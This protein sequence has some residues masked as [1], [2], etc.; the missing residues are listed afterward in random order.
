[1]V[2][3]NEAEM[4]TDNSNIIS[5]LTFDGKCFMSID[6]KTMSI[7]EIMRFLDLLIF[8]TKNKLY[9]S[10]AQTVLMANPKHQWMDQ[11]QVSSP[12]VMTESPMINLKI[13]EL[14]ENKDV[15]IVTF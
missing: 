5:G 10:N 13:I 11:E 4:M 12:T 6:T 7:T 9:L 14:R 3:S 8:L 15:Q 2:I 1:M